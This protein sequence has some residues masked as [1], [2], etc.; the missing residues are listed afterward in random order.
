M[1]E[2][3]REIAMKCSSVFNYVLNE[4]GLRACDTNSIIT[5]VNSCKRYQGVIGTNDQEIND[6]LDEL[7]EKSVEL[8]QYKLKLE[9]WEHLEQIPGNRMSL[10]GLWKKGNDIFNLALK[11]VDNAHLQSVLL[12]NEAMIKGKTFAI[13]YLTEQ[14]LVRVLVRSS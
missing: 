10:Q 6:V 9:N 3:E 13:Q 8:E 11:F 4:L 7:K 12:I 5:A 14:V 2:T 1:E